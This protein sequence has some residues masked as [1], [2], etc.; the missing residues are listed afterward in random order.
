MDHSFQQRAIRSAC[1]AYTIQTGELATR[2]R[3]RVVSPE[4]LISPP[5]EMGAK[6]FQYFRPSLVLP[7]WF[8]RS[9][10][11]NGGHAYSCQRE[12]RRKWRLLPERSAARTELEHA[13]TANTIRVAH[14]GG[15]HSSNRPAWPGRPVASHEAQKRLKRCKAGWPFCLAG[16]DRPQTNWH[17]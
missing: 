12:T 2:F 14:D 3:R 15:T 13:R 1:A 7:I 17:L 6:W 10:R 16:V 9:I 5:R 11:P 8:F 4:P